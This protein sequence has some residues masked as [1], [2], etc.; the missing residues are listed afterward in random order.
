MA[1]LAPR[2]GKIALRYWRRQPDSW[3]KPGDAGPVSEADLAVDRFLKAEL[4]AARPGYGWLSEETPDDPARLA[5]ERVFIIDPID[6]TRAYLAGEE[7][8]AVSLAVAEAGRITAALVYLPA[9]KLSY[10]AHADGAA[11][12]NGS[13]IHASSRPVLAG[14]TVLA[15]RASL[16]PELW[17]NGLPD[18]KQSFRASLAWRFCRAAEGREDAM[19]SLRDTWEWDSAAGSLIAERAGCVVS[20]RHGAKLRFN[21]PKPIAE[22]VIAAPPALHAGFMAGLGAL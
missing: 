22:G 10:A 5:H 6:G 3:M 1:E 9:R 2:A 14:A 11:T 20:D 8:F 16:K 18:L 7:A 4:L 12:R 21:Q 19:L 17:P 13:V 15:N